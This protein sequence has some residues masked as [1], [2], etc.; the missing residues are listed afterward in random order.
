LK[1]SISNPSP[2]GLGS[3]TNISRWCF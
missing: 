1:N 3:G 2:E